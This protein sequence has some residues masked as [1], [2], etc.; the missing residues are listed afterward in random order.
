MD[1]EVTILSITD[2]TSEV[3]KKQP[4]KRGRKPNK[5]KRLEE[6]RPLMQRLKVEMIDIFEEYPELIFN[7]PDETLD[8]ELIFDTA[9]ATK[10]R[11]EKLKQKKSISEGFEGKLGLFQYIIEG[12]KSFVGDD[13]IA[14]KWYDKRQYEFMV[15]SVCS[16]Q[17]IETMMPKLISVDDTY[18]GIL[19]KNYVPP[20][21]DVFLTLASAYTFS[22]KLLE[23]QDNTEI[24]AFINNDQ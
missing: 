4:Q 19:S 3:P 6:S 12:L 20:L 11:V 9:N 10:A 7:I 15:K 23:M 24:D 22:G 21:L 13:F 16:K 1:N 2:E 5:V 18:N 8:Y 17:T 14:V